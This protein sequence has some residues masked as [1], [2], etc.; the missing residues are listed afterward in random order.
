MICGSQTHFCTVDIRLLQLTK[1]MPY[2]LNGFM[3]I[4]FNKIRII[5]NIIRNRKFSKVP[6]KLDSVV[7]VLVNYIYML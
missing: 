7:K 2:L 5:L 6:K 4:I 1:A 3:R